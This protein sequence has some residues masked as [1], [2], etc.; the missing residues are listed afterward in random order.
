MAH[1]RGIKRIQQFETGTRVLFPENA[2]VENGM[3]FEQLQLAVSNSV[4]GDWRIL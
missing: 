4:I 3:H 2:D 1:A